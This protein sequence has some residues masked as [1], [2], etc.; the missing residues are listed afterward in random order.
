MRIALIS[1]LHGNAF[2]VE[3]ALSFIQNR[4]V[5]EIVCLGDVATLGAEPER[6]LELLHDARVSCI[7]GN[8]DEFMLDAELVAA[9]TKIPILVDAIDWCRDRLSRAAIDLIRGFRRTHELPLEDGER[10]FLFHG[11][12]DSNTTDLLA[13]TEAAQLDEMLKDAPGAVLAG[14]HTHLQ[15]LRQHRG[16]LVVNPGSVGMPF[17]TYVAGGPPEVLPFAELAIVD[18]NRASTSVELHRVLLDKSELRRSVLAVEHPLS[19]FLAQ[20]YA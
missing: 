3:K 8:H 16:R 2:A 6:V 13:T 17:K 5:D 15:M 9:Y 19:G 7:L 11:T 18:S 20:A 10:L 14:G 12:P 4:G 1:D